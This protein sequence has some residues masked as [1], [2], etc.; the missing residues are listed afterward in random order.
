M[1]CHNCDTWHLPKPC[2]I[3]LEKCSQCAQMGHRPFFCPVKPIARRVP[4]LD[5]GPTKAGSKRP[6]KD[7]ETPVAENPQQRNTNEAHPGISDVH[8]ED[9]KTKLLIASI[10]VY[11]QIKFATAIEVINMLKDHTK[12]RVLQ[13]MA[14][15]TVLA[16]D[17]PALQAILGTEVERVDRAKQAQNAYIKSGDGEGG[18]EDQLAYEKLAAHLM[19]DLG[20]D[21]SDSKNLVDPPV[22]F[23]KIIFE[24]MHNR[25]ERGGLALPSN[26]IYSLAS[27]G[28]VQKLTQLKLPTGRRASS[29]CYQCKQGH[30]STIG[31]GS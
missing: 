26:T 2:S 4:V 19:G 13:A 9:H 12:E 6:R 1:L 30:V 10:E 15:A 23:S 28:T 5:D 16:S 29:R 27:D 25:F 31:K 7:S 17:L 20:P 21:S 3:A 14:P 24:N 8:V 22:S 18:D 11:R